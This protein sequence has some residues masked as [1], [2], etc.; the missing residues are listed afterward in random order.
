MRD[1]ITTIACVAASLVIAGSASASSTSST[2]DVS[3]E[4][5]NNCQISAGALSFPVAQIRDVASAKTAIDAQSHIDVLCTANSQYQLA[6]D[7]GSNP[8]D[9]RR[10]MSNDSGGHLFYDL[11]TDQGRSQ[12]WLAGTLRDGAQGSATGPV[13]TVVYGRINGLSATTQSGIYRDTLT[14]TV[15]F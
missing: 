3:V 13:R 5:Q 4:V 2:M 7:G 1:I 14:V 15:N 11:Y 12:E 10:A 6:I 8:V 9:G